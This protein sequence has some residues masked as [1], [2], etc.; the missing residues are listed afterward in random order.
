MREMGW[1]ILFTHPLN[2][3]DLPFR[4]LSGI[5]DCDRFGAGLVHFPE[6][7]AVSSAN[8][9]GMSDAEREAN[10]IE[11][12]SILQTVDRIT[13]STSFAVIARRRK[14]TRQSLPPTTQP[15]GERPCDPQQS[16]PPSS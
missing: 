1:S 9:G 3:D 14:P 6:A 2:R 8:T 13:Q 7:L 12:D 15:N 16:S 10:Q 11:L 4:T 5:V